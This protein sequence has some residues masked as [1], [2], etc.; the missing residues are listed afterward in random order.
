MSLTPE[1]LDGLLADSIQ[2]SASAINTL[3][4]VRDM[5]RSGQI[6]VG[7]TPKPVVTID[8]Q[9]KWDATAFN[10]SHTDYRIMAAVN[11]GRGKVIDGQDI[12]IH[13]TGTLLCDQYGV[14]VLNLSSRCE[15]VEIDGLTFVGEFE[16]NR[17][18][19]GTVGGKSGMPV[20]IRARG[21]RIRLR[22]LT[23]ENVGDLLNANGGIDGLVDCIAEDCVAVVGL[24]GYAAYIEGSDIA[25]KGWRVE[26]RAPSGQGHCFRTGPCRRV[27]IH[28][29]SLL[30]TNGFSCIRADEIDGLEVFANHCIEGNIAVDSQNFHITRNRVDNGHVEIHGGAR[31]GLLAHNRI[32]GAAGLLNVRGPA[33]RVQIEHNTL[34]MGAPH[35]TFMHI[36]GGAS[37]MGLNR[38][39]FIATNPGFWLAGGIPLTKWFQSDLSGWTVRGNVFPSPSRTSGNGW[40]RVD[41]QDKGPGLSREAFAAMGAEDTRYINATEADA[42]ALGAGAVL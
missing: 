21:K 37:D 23:A 13:G 1:Q 42:E 34:L 24:T 30:R 11:V 26:Q 39:L 20:C 3:G 16:G 2:A 25:L 15:D 41:P 7:K 4:M 35:G 17:D 9:S 12:R 36:H 33:Q 6:V 27:K 8:S 28:D 5:L 14:E 22:G 32:A 40:H 38:N 29:N 18:S 19:A 10:Q 31:D